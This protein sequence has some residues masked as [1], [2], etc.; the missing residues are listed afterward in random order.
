MMECERGRERGVH[1]QHK[2]VSG[3]V[4]VY[5]VMQVCGSLALEDNLEVDEVVLGKCSIS[6]FCTSAF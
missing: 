3:G 1:S 6:C 5:P 4:V 2:T